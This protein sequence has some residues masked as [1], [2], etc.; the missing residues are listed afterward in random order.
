MTTIHDVVTFL[1]QKAPFET[2][3]EWDNVGLLV[4]DKL[5]QIQTV[6]VTLDIT[7]EIVEKAANAGAQLI[8]SHHPL[9][10]DPLKTVC[11]DSVVYRLIQRGIGAICMHT[12]LDKCAG[13]VNDTLATALGLSDVVVGP[14]GMS[15]I[16]RFSSPISARDFADLVA[17]VLNT[18]VRA[19]IGSGVV[20][21]VALCG[22]SGAD[23]VLP[24][25]NEADAAVTSELKH[26]EWLSLSSEKTV[27]DGGHFETEVG[28]TAVLT[29]WLQ[30]RFPKL[31]IILGEQTSP[32]TT[33][34][35]E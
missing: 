30:E 23:L 22:G 2:A 35:K 3:E 13:G 14:D 10:F 5:S 16:G 27:V 17:N 33:I 15:R 7:D 21:T 8:V 31:N 20:E 34:V 28:V 6:Y 1:Q 24:L 25:L 9:I 12:N 18:S 4:G 26:H 29:C 19:R 32:Y 11:S